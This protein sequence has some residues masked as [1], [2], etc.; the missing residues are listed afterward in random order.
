MLH[1][2]LLFLEEQDGAISLEALSRHLDVE[3][4]ALAGMLETLQGMG[5]IK[6]TG[7]K[8]VLSEKDPCASIRCNGCPGVTSCPFAGETPRTYTLVVRGRDSDL[9]EDA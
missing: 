7:G 2:I 5:R 6:R 4:S 9:R 1:D 8:D 3:E